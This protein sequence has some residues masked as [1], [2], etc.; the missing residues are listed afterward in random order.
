MEACACWL[1]GSRKPSRFL[2]ALHTFMQLE[3]PQNEDDDD[4]DEDGVDDDGS[5]N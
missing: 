4:D 3:I 5:C 1:L 2:S